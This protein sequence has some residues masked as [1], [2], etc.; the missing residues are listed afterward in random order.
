MRV[1]V[2]DEETRA[3]RDARNW[4]GAY[5]MVRHGAYHMETNDSPEGR[6][7]KVNEEVQNV[8]ALEGNYNLPSK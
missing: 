6:D 3:D 1:C 2:V 4:H 5:H 8:G 7:Q